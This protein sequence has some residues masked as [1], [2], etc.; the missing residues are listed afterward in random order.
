M[1][2]KSSKCCNRNFTEKNC[3]LPYANFST[4]TLTIGVTSQVPKT[5]GSISWARDNNICK[6]GDMIKEYKLFTL[7]CSY[8]KPTAVLKH[9]E[10][11]TMKYYQH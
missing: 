4:S 11:Y 8:R 9:N 5:E 1:I 2:N 3:D 6:F 7:L 10:A